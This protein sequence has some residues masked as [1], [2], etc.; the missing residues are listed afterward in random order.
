M[1]PKRDFRINLLYKN[2]FEKITVHPGARKTRLSIQ[3]VWEDSSLL[4][5]RNL[6]PQ[7]TLSDTSSNLEDKSDDSWNRKAQNYRKR[8]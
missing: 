8:E 2:Y 6:K 3:Y 4:Y 1:C 7:E 5:P